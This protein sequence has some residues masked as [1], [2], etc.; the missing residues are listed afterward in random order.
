MLGLAWAPRWPPLEQRT[1]LS[2]ETVQN[3]PRGK[4][5]GFLKGEVTLATLEETPGGAYGWFRAGQL[6]AQPGACE[7]RCYFFEH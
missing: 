5:G 6:A 1:G 2:C 3:M 4:P 7:G